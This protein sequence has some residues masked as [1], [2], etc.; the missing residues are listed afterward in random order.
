M[1][2]TDVVEWQELRLNVRLQLSALWTSLMFFYV[3]ADL[4]AFFDPRALSALIEGKTQLVWPLT[5]AVRLAV[6]VMLSIPAAMIFLSLVLKAN[7]ARWVNVMTGGVYTLINAA[8]L[9]LPT[10]QFFYRYFESLE[11]LFTLYLVWTAWKWPT[12][13]SEAKGA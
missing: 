7:Y 13:S 4:L 5:Q 10:W 6:A 11:V 9:L 8:T 3:Y 2:A 1:A 12:Q